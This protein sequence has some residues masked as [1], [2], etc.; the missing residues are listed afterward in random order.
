MKKNKHSQWF[1]R[2]GQRYLLKKAFHQLNVLHH[3]PTAPVLIV[4]NHSNF[5]DSLVLFELEQQNLLPNSVVAVMDK[6]GLDKHKLFNG[7]G[8]VPVSTPMKLSEYKQLI[9][10]MK[11]HSLLIFPQG[12][13]EHIEKRPFSIEKGAA[14]LLLKNPHHGILF[15]SLYYSYGAKPKGEIACRMLHIKAMDRPHE[16]QDIQ[17][18]IETTMTAEVDHLKEDVIMKK[19]DSYTELW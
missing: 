12:K 6:A 17:H 10:L 16:L 18:F 9:S 19:F 14:S 4:V 7:L 15:V 1:F 8:V 2:W 11:Q 5:Y 3:T 13:E